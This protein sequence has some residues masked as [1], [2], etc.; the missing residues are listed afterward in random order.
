MPSPKSGSAGSAV[1]PIAPAE[2]EEADTA[3]PGEVDEVS[4]S[5]SEKQPGRYGSQ[6]AKPFKPIED[7]E[8]ET[9]WIEIELI[10][11]DDSPIPGEPYE[12]TLPDGSV[13]SGTLDEKGFAR[14]E[15]FEPGTCQVCFPRLDK[16]AWEPA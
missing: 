11:E 7:E 2:P 12:L 3:D 14:I 16:D 10:G 6:A 13:A 15:G 4:A 8:T 9:T 5:E 1:E